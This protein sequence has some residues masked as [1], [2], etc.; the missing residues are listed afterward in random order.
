MQLRGGTD[1]QHGDPD[2]I[3]IPSAVLHAT[4]NDQQASK[5]TR[6]SSLTFT[7][8]Y[9]L[10]PYPSLNSRKHGVYNLL[11]GDREKKQQLISSSCAV[12]RCSTCMSL[13]NNLIPWTIHP[14]D[15]RQL[16][17]FLSL[18]PKNVSKSS[19]S[20]RLVKSSPMSSMVSLRTSDPSSFS[21]PLRTRT[22]TA[23]WLSSPRRTAGGRCTTLSSL[24]PVV[25]VWGTSCVSLFGEWNFVL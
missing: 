21:R 10:Y 12:L 22:L 9:P 19:R 3:I 17:S 6:L 11:L 18:R 1:R 4:T 5:A 8:I 7:S 20:L 15:L 25:K 2:C 23:L 13:Y 24:C 14:H 16:M